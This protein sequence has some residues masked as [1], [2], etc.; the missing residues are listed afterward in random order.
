[1]AVGIATKSLIAAEK[2]AQSEYNEAIEVAKKKDNKT[3]MKTLR[4]IRDEEA[5][6]ESTLKHL[7]EV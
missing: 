1:M 4:H 7:G 3:A 5:E 2:K 6:H